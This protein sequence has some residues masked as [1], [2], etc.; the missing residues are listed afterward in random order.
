MRRKK[1]ATMSRLLKYRKD[2]DIFLLLL[3]A[4]PRLQ[5]AILIRQ[6]WVPWVVPVSEVD[7]AVTRARAWR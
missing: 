5:V 6:P 7:S 2:K 3:H 4:M 1:R